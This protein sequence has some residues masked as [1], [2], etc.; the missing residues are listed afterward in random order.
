MS[1]SG[2]PSRPAAAPPPGD[3]IAR[4]G[5][6]VVTGQLGRGGMGVVYRAR[7]PALAR[8]VAIKMVIDP[9][10]SP[11]RLDRFT[12]EA[13]AAGRIRHPGI[14]AV[15]EV[16][17]HEGRPFIVMDLI[18]GEPLDALVERGRIPP[19]RVAEIIRDLGL[20]L[21]HAHREGILHR[22]VKPQNVIIDPEGR[23]HLTD[24]GLAHDLADTDGSLTKTGQ[25]LGT[26]QYVAPEQARGDRAGDGVGPP[27]DVYG[28]GGVLYMRS[29]GRRPS[30]GRPS[31]R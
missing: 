25:L 22:D 30:M 17:V 5:R 3:G 14:V 19:R 4:I 23:P 20:A 28:L 13:R 27:A 21:D 31:S 1:G 11:Q 12:R 10:G 8:D 7:D 26:P 16:G 24:F 29:S 18:D 9:G 15:H 6:Y 2:P